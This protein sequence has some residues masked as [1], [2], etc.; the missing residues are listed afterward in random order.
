MVFMEYFDLYRAAIMQVEIQKL[1][2]EKDDV[3]VNLQ[4]ALQLLDS[5]HV[6]GPVG[7]AARDKFAPIKLICFPEYFLQGEL[8]FHKSGYKPSVK[9]L[10]QK[11]VHV[12]VPGEET[13][14]LAEK[15]VELD[16]Y[17]NGVVLEYDPEWGDD[18]VF[19]TSFII[20]PDGKI[21]LK[22]RKVMPALHFETAV[23]PH[24]LLDEYMKKY[25]QGKSILKVMFPVV[26]TSIG[27][28]GA[29]I[30]MDGHFPE[31]YRA[32][33]VQGAE[34][35]MRHGFMASM[36]DPPSNIWE[37]QNRDAA[38]ANSYYV[39]A[40]NIGVGRDVP[41]PRGITGGDSMIVD[42]NGNIVARAPHPSETI[43]VG[44]IDIRNLRRR[45]L[46]PGRNFIAQLRNEVFREIYAG[47]IYP[48]N[49]YLKPENRV[50]YIQDLYK[51]NVTYL[52]II[53]K[54]VEK[55]VYLKP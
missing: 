29:I 42:Y 49:L 39:C 43:V 40:A 55:R 33:G 15:A 37:I 30:C 17:I 35:V 54:L 3:K 24:D 47:T 25:G 12:Q 2:F 36:I 51:R 7:K 38:W 4:H 27:K 41:Y 26:E 10:N 16:A 34:V 22:Y 14:K 5:V 1:A 20:D 53:D 52:K 18:M 44:M 6:Y 46:D 31:C 11:G 21:I 45:R 28:L 9:E 13:D 8:F 23:S 48:A 19:N 50:Q 32:L